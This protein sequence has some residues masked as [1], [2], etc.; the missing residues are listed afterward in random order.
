[1][2]LRTRTRLSVVV[3][4][5]LFAGATGAALQTP[6]PRGILLAYDV[7]IPMRDG[8][9]L[10]ADVYRPDTTERV[11]VILVRTPYDNG[12]AGQ[13]T[14]GKW[15][16]GRGY[17]YVVQDVRGRGESDGEFYPLV[18]EATDG[19]DSITWCG[20]QPWSNGKV[21]MTG[22]SYLGW[23]QVYPAGLRNP[24]LA[25]L[26]AIVT[27]PDPYRNFPMQFGVLSPPTVSWLVNTSGRTLQDISQHDLAAVYNSLPL[28]D[29]DEKLGRHIRAWKDWV[30]HPANDAYW[31][32]QAYQ[33]RLLDAT[34]P[35]Y[36]VSGWYD[37]VLIGTLENFVAMTTKATEV[38]ARG[39]QRLLIGPW[40]HGVNR[41]RRMG[42]VD[43]GDDALI[44]LDGLQL[45]WFDRWLKGLD[46]GIEREPPVRVFVMGENRW[47]SDDRFPLTG[48][49]ETTY[50]LRGSGHA[51]S[52]FG[53][54]TLSADAPGADEK[55]DRYRY[56]PSNPVPFITE[57]DFHQIG[58]PDDYQAVERRDDVLVYSS[59]KFVEPVTVCG[60]LRAT[61]YASSS[62][63]DTDWTVKLLDVWP[64][65]FA[66]RLNDGIVRAR[67]RHGNEREDPLTPG[68]VEKYELDLW[69]T[70]Q[71]LDAGHRLRVE[72][73]SSA[74]PKFDR[75]LNTG[76]PLGKEKAGVVA[77]QTVYHDRAHPS[78]IVV[79]IVPAT[80]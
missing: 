24:H 55:A 34:V 35:I 80:R 23:T 65:G 46:N 54:G 72:V 16:A 1:V 39:R 11:P 3:A 9:T 15:W 33:S 61:I 62:A 76:G 38:A 78:H 70:C 43:F 19:D 32:A 29:M 74:F 5:V 27:P 59:D 50:Y 22:S 7:R 4:A 42:D 47:R 8:A 13:V 60:L 36:H 25:A 26:F 31:K 30:D 51:N 77:E 17:A 40:G 49:R 37:D 57:P 68:A 58:G 48:S 20:T 41:T 71:R 64:S 45:R 28:G 2:P 79:P 12:V 52:R 10:S 44:D 21:G 73:S 53:D 67:F 6:A 66:Q 75:N 63:R 56:D 18:T 69:G 14:L